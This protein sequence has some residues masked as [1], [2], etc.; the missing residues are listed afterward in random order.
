[1]AAKPI[2]EVIPWFS[3]GIFKHFEFEERIKSV[4]DGSKV[5][6][7]TGKCLICKSATVSGVYQCSTNF[8][9][10]VRVRC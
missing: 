8:L 7:M 1:M 6:H 3:R 5:T 10:H 4:T 9:W 2:K